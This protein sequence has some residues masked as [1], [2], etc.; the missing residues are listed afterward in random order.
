M[1]SDWPCLRQAFAQGAIFCQNDAASIAE[2][3][4]AA[5]SDYQQYVDGAEQARRKRLTRWAE[6]K[7]EL[8][9]AIGMNGSK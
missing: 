5:G 9:I 1:V 7:R 3:I 2:A 8:L 6:V 4:D